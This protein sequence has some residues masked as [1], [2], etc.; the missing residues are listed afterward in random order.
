MWPLA[1]KNKAPSLLPQRGENGNLSSPLGGTE[2]APPFFTNE[3][4]YFLCE[5]HFVYDVWMATSVVSVCCIAAQELV[6]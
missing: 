5:A 1:I 6:L 2:G 3:V 4:R